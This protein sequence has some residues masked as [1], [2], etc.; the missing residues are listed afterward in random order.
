MQNQMNNRKEKSAVSAMTGTRSTSDMFVLLTVPYEV[1]EDAGIGD[2][3]VMNITVEDGKIVIERA[4]IADGGIVCSGNC[5][6]CPAFY[7]DCDGDCE[8]CPC[9]ESCDEGEVF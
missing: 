1:F 3:S 5:E 8:A 6:D 7:A 9:Y 2:G 4:D